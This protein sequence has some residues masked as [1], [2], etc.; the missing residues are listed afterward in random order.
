MA[1]GPPGPLTSP[2]PSVP[3]QSQ[4]SGDPFIEDPDPSSSTS[5]VIKCNFCSNLSK[6]KSDFWRHLSERHFK[7]ELTKEL[8]TAPPFRCPYEGCAY[9]TKD[10]TISPLNA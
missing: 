6:T 8:P 9:E 7:S 10:K 3:K 1:P 2:G 4:Y 5:Y